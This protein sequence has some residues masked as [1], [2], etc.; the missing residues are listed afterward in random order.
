MANNADRQAATSRA[1]ARGRIEAIYRNRGLEPPPNIE[2]QIDRVVGSDGFQYFDQIR[3]HADRNRREQLQRQRFQPPASE[4]GGVVSPPTGAPSPP[5]QPTLNYRDFA[6]PWMTGQLL[7]LF[8]DQWAATGD[9]NLAMAAVRRSSAYD[10]V[11]V[12]NRRDDGS[13]RYTEGEYLSTRDAFHETLGEFGLG[14]PDKKMVESLFVNDVSAT[15]F[16]RG[17]ETAF[18]TFTEPGAEPPQALLDTFLDVFS[19]SGSAVDALQAV[20]DTTAYDQIFAGNRR[21]DGT[22]R[23]AEQDYYAYKRGWQSTLASYGLDPT[24]FEGRGRFVGSVEADLSIQELTQRLEMQAE[25]IVDNLDQVQEFYASNYGLDVTRESLLGAAI[26]PDVERDVLQGRITASQVGG[27]AALAGFT[28]SAQRAEQLARAG[29]TQTQ[30]R[31]V[32]SAAAERVPTLRAL[33]ARHHDPLGELGIDEFEE[34]SVLGDAE[35][36]RRIGRRLADEQSSFST[37]SDTLTDQRGAL[38][39]LRRR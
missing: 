13:L 25:Q 39:G 30:A 10:A 29:L 12:G 26:D 2:R 21:A 38:V 16:Y 7:D 6:P 11:F 15:E 1:S 35:A 34:A 9:A 24:F 22:L 31:Q 36:R 4:S 32:Y 3:S 8:V 37:R 23:M 33:A 17:V 18:S 14:Q 19:G 20:R 27:E 5:P 28:R